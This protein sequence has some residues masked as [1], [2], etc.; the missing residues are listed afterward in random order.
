[1]DKDKCV[2]TPWYM[3]GE[4]EGYIKGCIDNP[5][6]NRTYSE[7]NICPSCGKPTLILKDET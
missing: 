5:H 6:H 2:W 3:F 7:S 1:M 4:K